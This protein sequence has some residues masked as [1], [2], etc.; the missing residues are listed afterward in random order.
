MWY[1]TQT[2]SFIRDENELFNILVEVA[3]NYE[4]IFDPSELIDEL[5]PPIYFFSR[6][7]YSSKIIQTLAPELFNELV[8]ENKINWA[9]DLLNDLNDYDNFIKDYTLEDYL[10][11]NFKELKNIIWKEDIE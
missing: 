1:N 8:E 7:F 11:T 4:D 3:G 10:T 2:N 9:Q 5:Y 6:T